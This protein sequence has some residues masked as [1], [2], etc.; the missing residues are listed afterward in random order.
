MG[1]G[2]F[3]YK[4]EHIKDVFQKSKEEME[5][6][7][8][9]VKYDERMNQFIAYI[10][11][12][13]SKRL[14]FWEKLLAEGKYNFFSSHEKVFKKVACSQTFTKFNKIEMDKTQTKKKKSDTKENASK[15]NS[16]DEKIAAATISS[17]TDADPSES[18]KGGERK[19]KE[20]SQQMDG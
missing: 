11:K 18:I 14:E 15:I 9:V 4:G 16:E 12:E 6:R 8:M 17:K 1:I 7:F 20:T 10:L 5:H 19:I 3:L 13:K 2:V